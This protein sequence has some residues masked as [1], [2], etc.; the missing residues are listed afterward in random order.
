MF[1]LA[2][3]DAEFLN[4]GVNG[5]RSPEVKKIEDVYIEMTR[6]NSRPIPKTLREKHWFPNT[7]TESLGNSS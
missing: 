7:F 2:K 4:I 1:G 3:V 6:Q 5:G